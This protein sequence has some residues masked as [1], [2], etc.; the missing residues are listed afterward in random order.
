VSMS[1]IR[2]ELAEAI[3]RGAVTY[4]P[5]HALWEIDGEKASGWKGRSLREMLD[6]ELIDATRPS[7][8]TSE[9]VIVV[10]LTDAG[11]EAYEAAAA[12]PT[13]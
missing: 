4:R 7:K 8:V 11:R 12:P 1:K 2:R 13:G 9:T 5:G 3:S 6:D 10:R